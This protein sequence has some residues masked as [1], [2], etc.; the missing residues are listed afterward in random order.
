MSSTELHSAK[1][2]M[3]RIYA[4]VV[5]HLLQTYSTNIVIAKTNVTLKKY[6]QATDLSLTQYEEAFLT[7]LATRLEHS[8]EYVLNGI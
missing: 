1:E 2:I 3:L 8:N 4:E 6:T 5:N 7:A